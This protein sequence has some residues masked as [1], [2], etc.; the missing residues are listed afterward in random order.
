[1]SDDIDV[2]E[3][4]SEVTGVGTLLS[5]SV[6]IVVLIVAMVVGCSSDIEEGSPLL[7]LT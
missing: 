3:T 4:I 2:N 6:L 7:E 5:I 1:M